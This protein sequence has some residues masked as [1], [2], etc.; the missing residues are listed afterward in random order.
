[1]MEAWRHGWRLW[2][3]VAVG[4]YLVGAAVLTVVMNL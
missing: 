1:M 2:T 4:V 3:L